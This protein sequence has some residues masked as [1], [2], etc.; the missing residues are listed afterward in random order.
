M[1]TEDASSVDA[2]D[3]R[4][5][6][7][8]HLVCTQSAF[9][10]D[11]S[12]Q[13][14]EDIS[15]VHTEDIQDISVVLCPKMSWLSTKQMSWLSTWHMSCVSSVRE[16]RFSTTLNFAGNSHVKRMATHINAE[17]PRGSFY[18]TQNKLFVLT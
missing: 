13:D 17:A 3:R 16:L 7:K 15:S 10:E 5:L 11:L 9:T 6:Q 2:E 4:Y 8:M 12:S 18:T 14:T 1:Y